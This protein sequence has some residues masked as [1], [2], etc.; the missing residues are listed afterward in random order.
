MWNTYQCQNGSMAVWQYG[1]MGSEPVTIGECEALEKNY[2]TQNITLLLHTYGD[3]WERREKE[4]STTHSL[5]LVRRGEGRRGEG[6]MGEKG[7]ERVARKRGGRGRR[8]Q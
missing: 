3:R 7:E 6:V 8:G 4:Q 5:P 1:S 2:T